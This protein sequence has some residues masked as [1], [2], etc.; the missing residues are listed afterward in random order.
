MVLVKNLY[1]VLAKAIGLWFESI[2]G[3]DFLYRRMVRLVSMKLVFVVVCN[4]VEIGE[5]IGH[6]IGLACFLVWNLGC[7]MVLGFVIT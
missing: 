3:S 1:I 5:I 4:N 6:G 2:D 7:Y